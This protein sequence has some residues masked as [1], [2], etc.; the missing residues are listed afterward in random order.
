MEHMHVITP[1]LI[2]NR[3]IIL[4]YVFIIHLNYK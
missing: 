4:T 3:G 1:H 2:P